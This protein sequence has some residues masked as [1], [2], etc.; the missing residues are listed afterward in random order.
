MQIYEKIK[1][2]QLIISNL[3]ILEVMTFFSKI[4]KKNNL[5]IKSYDLMLKEAIKQINDKKYYE[6]YSS[7]KDNSHSYCLCREGTTK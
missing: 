3:I 6:K 7:Q 5:P 2:E 1:D 4:N